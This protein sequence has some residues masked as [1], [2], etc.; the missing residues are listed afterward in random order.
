MRDA[1]A[2][3]TEFGIEHDAR[4][5]SRPRVTCDIRFENIES[6]RRAAFL[7]RMNNFFLELGEHRLPEKGAA[8]VIDFD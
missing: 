6:Q 2:F 7:E 1:Q 3:Q 8:D 4:T 5:E